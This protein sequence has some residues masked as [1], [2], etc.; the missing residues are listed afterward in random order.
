MRTCVLLAAIGAACA[1]SESAP[2]TT[3]AVPALASSLVGVVGRWSDTTIG[4]PAVLANGEAWSGQHERAALDSAGRR[5]FNEATDSFLDNTTSP[6]AFPFAV[7]SDVLAFGSGTLR[8]EFNL[9]GGQS[10]QIAGILFGLRPNGEYH[11]VRYNTKD[12]NLALWRFRDGDREVITHGEVHKQLPLGRWHEL[13]VELNGPSV[14][15]YIAGDTTIAV[16]H[17]LDAPQTG[18]VGV[19]AKR[20]AITAFRNFTAQP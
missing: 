5:L 4:T 11:Y 10:D 9:V 2:D 1:G 7:A 17:T 16:Q 6:T 3:Q 12:G 8:V 20:D 19:W 18:R 14:R 13:V 15:G